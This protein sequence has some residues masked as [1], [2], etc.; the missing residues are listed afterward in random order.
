MLEIQTKHLPVL[1][2]LSWRYG[3]NHDWPGVQATGMVPATETLVREKQEKKIIFDL[4][5]PA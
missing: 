5:S 3:K 4:G 1:T 2:M